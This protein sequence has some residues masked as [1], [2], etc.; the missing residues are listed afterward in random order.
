MLECPSCGTGNPDGSRFCNSCGTLL[1]THAAAV[2][3]TVTVL[4]C[5]LVGSTAQGDG[6]DPEVLREQ[7]AS[8]HA[9]LRTILEHH[10]GTVEKF[11]GDA[12][13]AVY[14]L[15]TAHEDDAL[16]AVRAAAEIL[17]AVRH[18]NLEV[19]IGVNTGEIVAGEG[20]T[21][22]TG[23]AVNVA[24]R[25]EQAAEDGQILIGEQTE[26]LV[27]GA[28]RTGQPQSLKVKGKAAPVVAHQLLEVLSAAGDQV[29][30][31]DAPF[32]GR[33]V[34][35]AA[36]ERAL[37]AAVEQREP[38]LATVVG[39]PGIGKS[40]LLHEFIGRSTARVVVGR[41]LSYGQG[42]TY[43]PL[44]EI[45]QQIG[46]VMA[47]LPAGDEGRLAASRI[48][49][50]VGDG[51]ATPDEIAWGFRKLFEA[52]AQREPLIVIIDDIHWAEPTLLDLIEYIADFGR[53]AP[54]LLLCTARPELLETRPTW[55]AP[56]P[57]AAV[58]IME[59][60]A[61]AEVETLVGL[62]DRFHAVDRKRI[63]EAAEGNP[64]FVEQLVAMYS[65]AAPA[66]GKL[67]IPPT[68][69]ALLAARI[70]KLDADE[71]AV[72]E[73]ASIEGRLFHRGSVRQLLPEPAR[74]DVGRRLL[75]LVRR[76]FISPDQAELPGDDGFRFDHILIRDAAYESLPK[77][78][79]AELHER[80]ADWL[81]ERL[82]ENAPPEIVGY[83]L[84]QAH[85]YRKEL[86]I[87]DSALSERAA[88]KLI[89]AAAS[90][91]A[92]QDARAEVVLLERAVALL[93]SGARQ[94]A[95]ALA[96]LGTALSQAAEESRAIDCLL[97]AESLARADRDDRVEWRARLRRRRIEAERDPE[98]AAE[99]LMSEGEAALAA[100][101]DDD[102]V[103]ARAW[104]LIAASHMWRGQLA[105]QHGASKTA[106]EHARRSD[107]LRLEVDAYF[108][109]GAALAFGPIPVDEG[110]RWVAQ[111]VELARNRQAAESWARHMLA[112]LHARLGDFEAA[113]AAMT[114]WR[115]QML[116]LGQVWRY[117]GTADCAWDVASLAE[118]W[119]G[120]EKALREAAAKFDETGDRSSATLVHARLAEALF[121]QGKLDEA[122]RHARVSE[123]LSTPSDP[124]SEAAW[125]RIKGRIMG[126]RGDMTGAL[127]VLNEAVAILA[128]TD[129]L[130]ER[131]AAALDLAVALRSAGK[132]DEAVTSI[133]DAVALYDLKGNLV[134]RARA[135]ALL[136][137][138]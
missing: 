102:D 83:H 38:R 75:T 93:P 51:S 14:G 25:L 72:I 35:L 98:R 121:L 100:S 116:E 105:E 108:Q 57:K 101:P 9:A 15:P 24:A 47:V 115:S 50:A 5:D 21:L 92:R 58:H 136:E 89:T 118:D 2:R 42:I 66:D 90:A 134:G 127:T 4:F 107:D 137:G 110:F 128:G 16:R 31:P 52:L 29:R 123:E 131:A 1:L 7:L 94:R 85:N 122:E 3:K 45:T 64:L 63:I 27:R 91:S 40:R 96:Q 54:M 73:R 56:R 49:A 48:T 18:L 30:R 39:P 68:I 133:R 97:E 74:P 41:C 82:V 106:W 69:Q 32:V 12:A 95:G 126:E 60:L 11:I 46:E 71:R 104:S 114:A 88:D 103:R 26:R 20:E 125:R 87:T 61:A 84:E 79:R 33:E 10:G 70:D 6:A 81:E 53:D 80:F 138:R 44:Q 124:G 112:H 59:P 109:S 77:R 23:D 76:Q 36:L 132:E 135:E 8:Y 86:G 28:V 67:E 129:Y 99:L 130:D 120:G 43:W 117:Y 55:S 113:Q 22:V 13:M 111:V 37:G 34:E 62:L 78:L 19:R 65:E 119:A 17:D